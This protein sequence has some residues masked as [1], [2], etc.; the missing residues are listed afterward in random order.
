VDAGTSS[1][2]HSSPAKMFVFGQHIYFNGWIAA[3]V[4]NLTGVNGG[5]VTHGEI[6]FAKK[7]MLFD[8][9]KII[10]GRS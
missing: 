6:F 7:T 10:C 9:M 3:T 1:T 4:Q 5:D 2:G 8:Y